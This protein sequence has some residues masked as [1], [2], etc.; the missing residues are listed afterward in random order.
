MT[1]TAR[2]AAGAMTDK[3]QS[4]QPG[5]ELAKKQEAMRLRMQ[6][7][8]K[9]QDAKQEQHSK[10][11]RKESVRQR[12]KRRKRESAML[13][14]IVKSTNHGGWRP[15]SGRKPDYIKR[16]GIPPISA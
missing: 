15:N 2:W 1:L 11:A 10:L 3:E 4:S 8:R 7:E 14:A 6:K 9:R 5:P 13:D 12:R 16:I